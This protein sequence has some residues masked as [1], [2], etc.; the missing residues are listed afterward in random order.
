MSRKEEIIAGLR[1]ARRQIL[2]AV[3]SLLPEKRDEVFLGSWSIKD[4]LA[5]LIGWDFTNIEAVKD[6]RAGRPP[7]VFEHWDPD[8][9][10]YNAELV[11]RH[12][13]EDFAELLDSVQQSHA[14]LIEFVQSIP[15]EDIQKDFGI[16]SPSGTNITVEG[17]L[18]FEIDDEGRHYQQIQDWLK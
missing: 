11:G 12:K 13:R 1:E 7:R 17:F 4:L 15:A 9:V 3:T 8:W 2:E 6:I 18:Q 14:A 16:R 5:H 10:K